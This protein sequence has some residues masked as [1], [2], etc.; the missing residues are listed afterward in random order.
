[1]KTIVKLAVLLTTLLLL[2]GAA[3]A[4][5]ECEC[6]TINATDLDNPEDSC[7]RDVQICFDFGSHKGIFTSPKYVPFPKTVFMPLNMYLDAMN[8][9]MSGSLALFDAVSLK[10]HG[11]WMHVVTGELSS[12]N[13]SKFCGYNGYHRYALHGHRAE[14]CGEQSQQ[15]L[16]SVTGTDNLIEQMQTLLESTLGPLIDPE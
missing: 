11:D 6:Y 16:R 1:M 2:S 3:F 4:E 13:L 5:A 10:F 14:M 7:T 15:S 12:T 8:R 9:K